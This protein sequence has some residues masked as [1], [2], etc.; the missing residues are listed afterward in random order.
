MRELD[1]LDGHFISGGV[2]VRA[3]DLRRPGIGEFPR[4]GRVPAF[5]E[6]LD[7]DCRAL[8]GIAF[9]SLVP[10]EKLVVLRENST[11]ESDITRLLKA[12]HLDGREARARAA[13]IFD[14]LSLE[15]EASHFLEQHTR[16]DTVDVDD[17]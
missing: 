15:L 8:G 5:V 12:R 6:Q 16:R 14:G 10:V 3:G 4:H 17:K 2:E 7:G 1:R 13:P 9:Y 11:L